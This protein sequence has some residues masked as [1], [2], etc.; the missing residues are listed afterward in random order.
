MQTRSL[1]LAMLLLGPLCVGRS[2]EADPSPAGPAS[3]AASAK[4][5]VEWGAALHVS[6]GVWGRMVDLGSGNWLAVSTRFRRGTNSILKLRQGKDHCQSWAPLAEVAEDG[7]TLDNGELVRLP[8]GDLLLTGRS[9]VRGKSYQLPVYRSRDGGRSWGRLSNVDS[10]EGNGERGLWE[11][12]FWVLGDG[13]LVV[14]YSNEQH[15]GFSQ[16]ISERI[17]S[18]G[19]ATWGEEIRAVAE[20]G[21]GKLRPGMSQMARLSDGRYLLVY[22][23]VGVGNGDVHFKLSEDGIHWPE[24]LGVA[25]PGQH[26]GPFVTVL[27]DGRIVVTSCG[28]Q[29]SVSEDSGVSWRGIDPPPWALGFKFSWPA[30]YVTGT[31]EFGVMVS[32]RGVRLRVGVLG[33]R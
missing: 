21:G 4:E 27:P 25:I 28:N 13:R 32:D 3:G 20:P 16:L 7:R 6:D 29:L 12:D 30:I 17:S 5:R 11:P 24:G 1:W 15:P 9:L 19:G 2:A 31:N 33:K 14:T 18:D 22:E 26:C 10:S 23:V 8:G